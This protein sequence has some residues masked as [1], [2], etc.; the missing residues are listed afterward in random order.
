MPSIIAKSAAS[1]DCLFKVAGRRVNIGGSGKIACPV[2]SLDDD[3]IVVKSPEEKLYLIENISS[4]LPAPII[5][6]SSVS[7]SPFLVDGDACGW[8]PSLTTSFFFLFRY[9]FSEPISEVLWRETERGFSTTIFD[10][11][12]AL[13]VSLPRSIDSQ[14]QC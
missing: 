10:G 7:A 4:F 1:S 6:T 12:F 9:I 13:P 3:R 14:I 2:C 11:R 5:E 8:A